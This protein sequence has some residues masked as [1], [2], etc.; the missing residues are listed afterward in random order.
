MSDVTGY[1]EAAEAGDRRA[2]AELLP[3]VNDELRKLAA[4]RMAAEVPGHTLSATGL[5]HEAGLHL[6]GPALER[7]YANR[8][9]SFATAAEAMRRILV[10]RAGSRRSLRR[11]GGG[12]RIDLE[13]ESLASRYSDDEMQ[14]ADSVLETRDTA[15]Q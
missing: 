11:G 15:G 6:L 13:I 10:D 12:E 4:A 7:T 1:L 5:V 2:A 14:D 8:I 9:Y 3:L